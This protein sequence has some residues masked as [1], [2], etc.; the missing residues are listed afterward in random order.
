MSGINT[1][2]WQLTHE[3]R[4]RLI[5]LT[6]R[7]LKAVLQGTISEQTIRAAELDLDVIGAEIER[8]VYGE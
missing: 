1:G 3:N 6:F 8:Y 5:D 7:L 4:Q 2:D